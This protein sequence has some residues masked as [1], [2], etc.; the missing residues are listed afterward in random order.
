MSVQLNG[1]I[2]SNIN[3]TDSIAG[4]TAK[5]TKSSLISNNKYSETKLTNMINAVENGNTT[6]DKIA[7]INA[8]DIDWNG[9]QWLTTFGI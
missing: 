2:F 1:M 9:A 4:Y 5:R 7:F 3:T 8:V 6:W